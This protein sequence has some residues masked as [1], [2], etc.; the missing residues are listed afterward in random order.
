MK[1]DKL[2]GKQFGAW[3]V[4]EFLGVRNRN[5]I[6]RCKCECGTTRDI[7]AGNLTAGRTVSC[8]CKRS[9]NAS[10]KLKKH[11]HAQT[12]GKRPSPTYSTWGSMLNRCNNPANRSYPRYGGRGIT[13]CDRWR[14]FDNF[15]ADMGEK[16]AK[17]MSI[18]RLDVNGNYE[19]GNC[20]W[21]T[22]TIQARNTRRTKL[23]CDI[24]RDIKHQTMSI[25]EAVALT[26]CAKSTAIAARTGR[27]W[28]EV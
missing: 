4:I 21:A 1:K 22:P 15:L 16:P 19:P 10:V 14:D 26:G 11:G 13:V 23:N 7:F 12:V 20:V 28:K 5:S 2:T 18:E 27:N 8:G 25:N 6:Y 24:A 17:G 3:S 9:Q